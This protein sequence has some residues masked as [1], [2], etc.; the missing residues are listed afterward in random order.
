M[1]SLQ[2]EFSFQIAGDALIAWFL[3]CFFLVFVNYLD[4][5]ESLVGTEADSNITKKLFLHQA[6]RL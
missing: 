3:R 1:T 6:L 4:K 5:P 2:H